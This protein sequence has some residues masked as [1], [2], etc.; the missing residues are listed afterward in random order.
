MT[1]LYPALCRACL[2]LNEAGS[3]DAFARI[4]ESVWTGKDHRKPIRGD[5]GVQFALDPTKHEEFDQWR[6]TF[7]TR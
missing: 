3:C 2:R 6:R 4:P 7:G 1:V 5:H